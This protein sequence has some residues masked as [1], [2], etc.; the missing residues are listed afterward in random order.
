MAAIHQDGEADA[1]RP[2]QVTD[3]VQ[4][5]ADR[6]AG[7]EDVVHQNDIGAV[8]VERNLRT[9]QHRP[10]PRCAQVVAIE[11]DID[12]TDRDLLRPSSVCQLAREPMASGTPRVRTPTRK[13]GTFGR[14]DQ[15]AY[16]RSRR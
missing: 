1:C 4:G 16:A 11:R 15:R 6:P 13:K 8:D 5:R 3:G 12:G 2:S 10:G 9:V 14:R 7:E